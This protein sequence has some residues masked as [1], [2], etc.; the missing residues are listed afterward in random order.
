MIDTPIRMDEV[1]EG[2]L[3][4]LVEAMLDRAS[5][6][7]SLSDTRLTAMGSYARLL[8]DLQPAATDTPTLLLRAAAQTMA[9]EAPGPQR[10]GQASAPTEIEV[11]GDH[12]SMMEAHADET[13]RTVQSWLL[14]NT[15][16]RREQ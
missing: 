8:G 2:T 10:D 5:G 11:P 7:M 13:A 3:R 4:Q 6:Y 14:E 9:R 12:F 16:L 1:S 15:D